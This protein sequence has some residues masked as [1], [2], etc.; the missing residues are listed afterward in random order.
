[1]IELISEINSRH[2]TCEAKHLGHLFA[3]DRW[4]YTQHVIRNTLHRGRKCIS[5]HDIRSDDRLFL[6]YRA[7]S[8]HQEADSQHSN[9]DRILC[10]SSTNKLSNTTLPLSRPVLRKPKLT[11][12]DPSPI[13]A[14][15]ILSVASFVPVSVMSCHPRAWLEAR[16]RQSHQA[17]YG[18]RDE[19][20]R[21]RDL[22]M[23]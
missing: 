6:Y 1:M 18:F 14:W 2:C 13:L 5:S 17:K 19:S 11:F 23:A 21:H 22:E 8:T 12:Y 9:V 16:I 4:L 10:T 15:H 3:I 20:N 7:L